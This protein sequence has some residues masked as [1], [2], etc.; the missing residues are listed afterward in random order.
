MMNDIQGYFNISRLLKDIETLARFGALETGGI[1]RPAFSEPCQKAERWLMQAMRAAG[2]SVT[3]DAA[4][5]IIGRVGAKGTPAL[6]C[7]SHIDTVPGGGA[8]DGALG[9]MAALECVRA[10]R[11]SGKS[12]DRPL[13]VVAFADEEGAYFSLLGSKAM[14]GDIEAATLPSTDG[15]LGIAMGDAGLDV[16]RVSEAARDPSEICAYIEL[17]IEQGPVLERRSLNVG[18]VEAIVGM[19]FARYVLEGQAGHAGST[20]MLGRC[21]ALRV[22]ASATSQSFAL[23]DASKIKGAT[24]TFGNISVEP[25]AS[26]VI[27]SRVVVDCEV[28]ASSVTSINKLRAM[29]D[30]C[31]EEA[32][33]QFGVR[34]SKGSQFY[35]PPSPL[36]VDLIGRIRKIADERGVRYAVLPS[37]ACHDAQVFASRVPTAMIFVRSEG[38]ISH[39]PAEYSTPE[40]IEA[41]SRLLL[42]SIHEFMSDPILLHD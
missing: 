7:G 37:G 36:S 19:D 11:D 14:V 22:A 26:N 4:G 39:N 12:F 34:L 28:R 23:V 17:H 18:I 2:M 13:E 41:G 29:V 20:P 42:D 6:V 27:P 31:F 15:D 25:G 3:R 38:G 35:D 9:V 1:K 21:D 8:Y 5:N 24:L 33:K 16:R 32:A 10:L 40:A 30:F